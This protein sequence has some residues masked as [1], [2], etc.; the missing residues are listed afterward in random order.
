VYLSCF[1]FI[2]YFL[3]SQGVHRFYTGKPRV[4]LLYFCTFGVCGLGWLSDIYWQRKFF[5][6]S[7]RGAAAGGDTVSSKD[8][9][10]RGKD[11]LKNSTFG[12][13]WRRN[14]DER[15]NRHQRLD[16]DV[17]GGGGTALR[18]GRGRGVRLGR[19]GGRR[20]AGES[21]G[22][23]G[24]DD[25]NFLG[26]APPAESADVELHSYDSPQG[27]AGRSCAVGGRGGGGG[28][29]GE[30]REDRGS[31]DGDSGVNGSVSGNV[32]TPARVDIKDEFDELAIH[33]PSGAR[34][35]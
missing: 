29:G 10:K 12:E 6:G 13:Q 4:G 2:S 11:L 7:G 17:E 35:V 8:V 22:E 31:G 24:G 21:C 32:P 30:E 16:E 27:C 28:G 20:G 9:L 34:R 33:E 5:F 25:T 1:Y 18:E 15:R 23:D 19:G 26:D 3:F 14:R